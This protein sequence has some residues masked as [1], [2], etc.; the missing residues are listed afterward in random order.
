M[1]L[2]FGCANVIFTMCAQFMFITFRYIHKRW[3]KLK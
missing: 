2:I 1:C 3:R